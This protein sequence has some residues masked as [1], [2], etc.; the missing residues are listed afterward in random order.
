MEPG[1]TEFAVSHLGSLL[2]VW[3][4]KHRIHLKRDLAKERSARGKTLAV[5]GWQHSELDI[6]LNAGHPVSDRHFR[7]LGTQELT[8][9]AHPPV[10]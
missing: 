7:I 2:K 10:L 8:S 6:G 9:Q 1:D 3:A 4:I 5:V